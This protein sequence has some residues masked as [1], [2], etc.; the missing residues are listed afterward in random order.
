[1]ERP[2]SGQFVCVLIK[3]SNRQ[4]QYKFSIRGSGQEDDTRSQAGEELTNYL[5]GWLFEEEIE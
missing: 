1:M 2:F 4:L 3:E 5:E